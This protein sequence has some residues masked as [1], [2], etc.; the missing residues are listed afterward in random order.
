MIASLR[1]GSFRELK[2]GVSSSVWQ[3]H[4]RPASSVICSRSKKQLQAMRE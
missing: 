2:M 1:V 4:Y 3:G